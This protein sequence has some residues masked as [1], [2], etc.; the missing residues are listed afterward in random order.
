M[1][2][3]HDI[4]PLSPD[5]ETVVVDPLV[6]EACTA[7]FADDAKNLGWSFGN[8]LPTQTEKWG[9]VWRADFT[10][11]GLSHPD[12]INRAICWSEPGGNILGTLVAFG[13]KIAP[14]PISR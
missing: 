3:F 4:P 2:D 14:L 9:F 8:S 1:G 5:R 10:V 11:H 12:F 7:H 13:Q 6:V